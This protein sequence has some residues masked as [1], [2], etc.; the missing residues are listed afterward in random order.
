MPTFAIT[1][2]TRSGGNERPLSTFSARSIRCAAV[3]DRPDDRRRYGRVHLVPPL[4]GEIDGIFAAISEIS[5]TGIRLM[6]EA[7]L[8]NAAEHQIRFKWKEYTIRLRGEVIRTT[9]KKLAKKAGESTLYESGVRI[10]QTVGESH[11]LLRELIGDFVV[12]SINEQL[13]NARGVPPLAAYSYQ[14]GKGD[15]Y[16]R[17]ELVNG[18]W[19]RVETTDPQQPANGF[20]ISAEVEPADL[21]LLCRTFEV[22]DAEGRRLTQVLA[23]L[24][25]S[26]REGIPTRRYVP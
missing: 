26:K 11:D 7:A 21:D 20:T 5:L 14:T 6:H 9:I 23:Q 18:S 12:R 25:I 19:R 17:C 16:R 3:I 10:T 15:R 8:P 13:A 22:C 1:S 24:S 4:R 2:R